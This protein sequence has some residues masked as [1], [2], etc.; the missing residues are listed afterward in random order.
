MAY[1]DEKSETKLVVEAC[2]IGLS[3]ILTQVDKRGKVGKGFNI[4]TAKEDYGFI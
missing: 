3:A 1:F 4:S 2:L